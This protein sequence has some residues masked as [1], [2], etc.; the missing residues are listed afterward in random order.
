MV[1]TRKD[2]AVVVNLIFLE[3][4]SFFSAFE[5]RMIMMRMCFKFGGKGISCVGTGFG[6]CFRTQVC[7][8]FGL[9]FFP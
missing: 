6:F 9:F 1:V 7:K 3:P 4:S 2:V 8:D 5:T